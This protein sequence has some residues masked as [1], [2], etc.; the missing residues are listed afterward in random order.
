MNPRHMNWEQRAEHVY[1]KLA[2]LMPPREK[3]RF[4]EY[5][6]KKFIEGWQKCLAEI[7]SYEDEEKVIDE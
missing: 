1:G 2:R 6:V 3:K 4:I 5:L 7:R